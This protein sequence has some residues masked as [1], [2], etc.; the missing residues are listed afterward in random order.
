MVVPCGTGA[1]GDGAALD[2]VRE[3]EAGCVDVAAV[4]RAVDDA[5]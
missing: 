2:V 4:L 1:A 5:G 3:G